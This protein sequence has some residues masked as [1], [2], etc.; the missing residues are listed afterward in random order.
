[1]N[2]VLVTGAAGFIGSAAT[3]ALADLGIEVL[4]VDLEDRLTAISGGGEAIGAT[5]FARQLG[6]RGPSPLDD[7]D[8][9]VHLG[10]N[11]DTMSL[12]VRSYRDD[13]YRLTA[14]LLDECAA[15]QLRC[16][17]A[18]SA[19]VYGAAGS[20]RDGDPDGCPLNVYG[21][22]KLAGDVRARRLI[23]R[24]APL[25]GL[26]FFNV[27]GPNEAHKGRMAS[28]VHQMVERV[29]RDEPIRLFGASHG[30]EAGAQRRDFIAVDDVVAVIEWAVHRPEVCGVIDC[31]TGTAMSFNAVADAVIRSFG[32]GTVEYVPFPDELRDRY[33]AHT[34][35]DPRILRNAGFDRPFTTIDDGVA[36]M[37]SDGRP[38]GP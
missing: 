7:V 14:A 21:W 29:R 16:V 31:G 30:V 28:M 26:R 25:L 32:Q 10:A 34:S 23:A 2:R 13:N 6:E 38:V 4:A 19:A 17:Y 24:G 12:D 5:A 1:M 18:S 35:A 15:R 20:A 9:V 8:A 36:R 3:S 33:Q 22:S 37:V 11:A 27:Y